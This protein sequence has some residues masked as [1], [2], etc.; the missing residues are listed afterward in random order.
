MFW[1]ENKEKKASE[2]AYGRVFSL[3]LF[4]FFAPE[5]TRILQHKLLLQRSWQRA[6]V[7]FLSVVITTSIYFQ[8][9]LLHQQTLSITLERT[10]PTIRVNWFLRLSR[11]VTLTRNNFR[12]LLSV[13]RMKWKQCFNTSLHWY[14]SYSKNAQV[15]LKSSN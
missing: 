12:P 15:R 4:H 10:V 3:S 11:F 9:L 7:W 8:A 2:R 6:P 1:Q 13:N 14:Y 5:F